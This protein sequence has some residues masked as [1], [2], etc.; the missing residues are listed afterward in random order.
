MSRSLRCV[1]S[2]L[3]FMTG[4]I[5][6]AMDIASRASKPPA[7]MSTWDRIGIRRLLMGLARKAALS[8]G[9]SPPGLSQLRLFQPNCPKGRPEIGRN[10]SKRPSTGRSA[11]AFLPDTGLAGGELGDS[12]DAGDAT[13][14]PMTWQEPDSW[15][16][17]A[18]RSLARAIEETNRWILKRRRA[19]VAPNRPAV[20]P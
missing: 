6:T 8:W 7:A 9:T 2:W 17:P 10:D 11:S 12:W 3:R 1:R 13:E 14:Q 4:M 16:I 20:R 18:T 5:A 19:G 15:K